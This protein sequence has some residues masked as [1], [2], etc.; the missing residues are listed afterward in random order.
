MPKAEQSLNKI[1]YDLKRIEKHREVLTE[2]KIRKI[3]KS[4]M[5]DLNSFLGEEYIKYANGDGVLTFSMLQEK[6]RE[7]RFLE[8]IV[9]KVDGIAPELRSEILTLVDETYTACYQGMEKAVRQASNTK[10][11]AAM[12]SDTVVRPEVLEQAVNNN[13]S[14]LTLP[15]VLERNRHDITYQIKQVLTIGL[16]NGDR[17]ETMAKKVN[18]VLCGEDGS[19][20]YYGKAVNIVRTESHRNIETGFMDCAENISKGLDGSGYVYTGT[21]RTMKDEKVRPQ[22]RRKTNKGWKTTISK[23][24][25]N[26]IKM[27]GVTIKV[28]DKFKLEPN[29]FAKCPSQSGKA[30]HDCNCRCFVEYDLMTEEE[31]NK[32]PNKQTNNMTTG[33]VSAAIR[34]EMTE[35]NIPDVG[36]TATADKQAFSDALSAAA[37]SNTHGGFVDEHTAE[38]LK[39]FKT[40][41]SS[42]KM[43]GVAVMPDGNITCVFKNSELKTRGVVNDLILTARENGG[44]KMDCYGMGLVNMYEKTGYKAVARIPFNPEYATDELLK[45]T[46]PDVYV[47]MKTEDSTAEVVKKIKNKS[48]KLSTQSDLDSLKTFEDY[49]EALLYRDSLL[50]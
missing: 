33:A 13:I 32:L 14:K 23:N 40:F 39:T 46:A 8:E 17:Y 29:V 2:K 27:E 41:L 20:G 31:F 44:T 10:E 47:L 1:L 43:T 24:G 26:H 11:L 15:D 50:K 37:K 5:K 38:E 36:L 19:G 49:D 35:A 3:Y 4:L 45:Q 48:Y 9:K 30:R 7:A 28:G 25:A 18:T 16:I 22:Q 12:M 21:W 42:D 34:Q 6:S